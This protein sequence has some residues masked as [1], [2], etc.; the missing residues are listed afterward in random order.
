MS[1]T[2]LLPA[3]GFRRYDESPDAHFYVQPRFVTHI[4]DPAIAAVSEIYRERLPGDGAILDLMSSWVSHLPAEVV[5]REVVGLGMN[6]DEL[7]ANPRLT[8]WLVHDLNVNPR[9]PFGDQEF[10][11][12]TICVSV[13][14]LTQP[15]TVF[16]E[17]GRLLRPDAPLIIT[18]SNRCFPTK[19]IDLW[20]RLGDVGHVQ[21][22]RRYFELAGNWAS[23]ETLDRSP[24][25]ESDPLFAVIGHSSSPTLLTKS[26]R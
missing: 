23:I 22:V 21:L 10:D 17:V 18:F 19:A 16:R 7:A 12:A 11:A 15:I 4:D 24:A 13:Q 26:G 25:D 5:Y 14:Y 1:E 3:D 9:L 8:R 20:Q 2:D 6:A